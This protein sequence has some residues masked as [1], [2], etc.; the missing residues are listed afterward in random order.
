MPINVKY[1]SKE[2]SEKFLEQLRQTM[3]DPLSL[4]PQCLHE[5]MLC[6]F[7]QYRKKIYSMVQGDKLYK[8]AG[9]ADQFL[10]GISETYKVINSGSIP[11]LGTI[12]TPFGNLE[13]SKRGNTDE[14][15]LS[16][17]QNAQNE[18][19][20]MLAFSSLVKNRGVRI[21]S[22][23]SRFLAS[24][25]DDA[26]DIGFFSEILDEHSIPHRTDGIIEIGSSSYKMDLVFLSNITIRIH[27]D[28]RQNLIPVLSKHLLVR[29]PEIDFSLSCDIFS[30]ITGEIPEDVKMQYLSGKLDTKSTIEQ[31]RAFREKRGISKKFYIIGDSVYK[32]AGEFLKVIENVHY[33]PNK[34]LGILEGL[35]EGIALETPSFR[36]L[37]EI[38]WKDHGD[39]IVS[40]YYPESG[41]LDRKKLGGDPLSQLNQLGSLKD[42]V[43]VDS[44][45]SAHAWSSDSEFLLE[46]A[47]IHRK[48]GKEE[49]SRYAERNLTND[50]RKSIYV[51]YLNAT[52]STG[53]RGWM[54][55][56]EQHELA[57]KLVPSMMEIISGDDERMR[58]GLEEIRKY[59]V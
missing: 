35:P 1:S 12:H 13:Y 56:P 50:M 27:D 51:A 23:R 36:K 22:S 11:I 55:S 59:G 32:T 43:E 33:D 53:N 57:L 9:S 29:N 34:L 18:T 19:F 49:V 3:E 48:R 40:I 17:I 39:Q 45:F 16:G 6:P 37:L 15:V 2:K 20:R 54:F 7:V 38:L 58:R 14:V 47:K 5:G 8:Y 25:K 46:M 10:S 26:P 52:G 24:C 44:S 42:E 28:Y 4:V 21:Y 31:I 30:E 41:Q